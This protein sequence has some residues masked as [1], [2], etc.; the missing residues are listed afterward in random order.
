M[1]VHTW[2]LLREE[3]GRGRGGGDRVRFGQFWWAFSAQ[4]L[5]ITVLQTDLSPP[6]I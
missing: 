4:L 5:P 2:K 3:A 6:I 1:H